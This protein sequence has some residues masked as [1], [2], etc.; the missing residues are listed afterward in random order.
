MLVPTIIRK[1]DNRESALLAVREAKK[2]YADLAMKGFCNSD[3]PSE[4]CGAA[5]FDDEFFYVVFPAVNA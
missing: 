4:K 5:S 1:F 2:L 3:Y